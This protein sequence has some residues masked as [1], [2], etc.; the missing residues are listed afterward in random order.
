MQAQEKPKAIGIG[1]Q[2]KSVGP[3]SHVQTLE[4]RLPAPDIGDVQSAA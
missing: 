4:R 3:H 1:Q 2:F